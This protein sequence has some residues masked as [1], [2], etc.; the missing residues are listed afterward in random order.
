MQKRLLIPIDF[1]VES[2]NTLKRALDGLGDTEVEAVLMYAEHLSDSISDLFFYSS[3]NKRKELVPLEFQEAL[4][5]LINRYE[6]VLLNVSI[7]FFHGYGVPS[8]K[9]FIEA[10]KID[11]I[12]IPKNYKLKPLKYGFDPIS[13]IKRSKFPCNEIEWQLKVDDIP[14]HPLSFLFI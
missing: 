14:E 12:Y 10:K 4:T 6:K 11:S 7:E 3:D 5:I 8:F 1:R 9:N 13:I 2:L